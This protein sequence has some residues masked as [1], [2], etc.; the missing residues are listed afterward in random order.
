VIEAFQIGISLALQDGVEEG[1][2]KA[3]RDVAAVTRAVGVGATSVQRLQEAG[4]AALTVAQSAGAQVRSRIGG[5]AAST[6]ARAPATLEPRVQTAADLPVSPVELPE[7]PSRAPSIAPAVTVPSSVLGSIVVLG[8]EGV[9]EARKPAASGQLTPS[10]IAPS[11]HLSAFA[12]LPERSVAAP[13][14]NV[15]AM[16]QAAPG[17]IAPPVEGRQPQVRLDVFG[18]TGSGVH[19]D[20]DPA[21]AFAGAERFAG[22]AQKSATPHD[23]GAGPRAPAFEPE[24]LRETSRQDQA[25]AAADDPGGPGPG[26]GSAETA[27]GPTHGD[28]FLDGALVGRWMSRLLSRE[29]SRATGGPTGFDPRRNALLPGATVGG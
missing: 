13:S 14:A 8:P 16:A 17:Q 5:E 4:V 28:V 9:T 21:F 22:N 23:T 19:P 6:Q 3:Q 27:H 10:A 15:Q 25:A 29:A 18:A 20:G 11:G 7:A 24:P 2:A 12:Q 26:R 1:I